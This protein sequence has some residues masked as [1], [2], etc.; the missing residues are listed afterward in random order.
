MAGTGEA[1]AIRVPLA[2]ELA[3]AGV[4][5]F[6]Y[7]IYLVLFILA[8]LS[9]TRRSTPGGRRFMLGS[10]LATFPL[11]TTQAVLGVCSAAAVLRLVQ[12]SQPV[13]LVDKTT[14]NFSMLS[15]AH[16]VVLAVNNLLTD[17]IFLHRCLKVWGSRHLILILPILL[18]VSTIV[19]GISLSITGLD[20]SNAELE[21][22][23]FILGLLTTLTLSL[24]TGG[25]IW[26]MRREITSSLSLSLNTKHQNPEIHSRYNLAFHILIESG[27]I[28]TICALA[29]VIS[30]LLPSGRSSPGYGEGHLVIVGIVH[31]AVNIVP[32]FI[33]VRAGLGSLSNSNTNN[34]SKPS[35][36]FTGTSNYS[37]TGSSQYKLQSST[38]PTPFALFQRSPTRTSTQDEEKWQGNEKVL[39]LKAMSV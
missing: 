25:K 17:I 1:T 4:S 32:I 15:T 11:A 26:W 20:S 18:M 36:S 28:Y 37:G 29:M 27:A 33:A 35:S 7:G 39:D 5:L 13:V 21:A 31:Q 8:I 2:G 38:R 3:K 10:T 34:S 23:P 9:L 6:L 16:Q 14:S 19:I 12:D 30:I 22:V 24:L